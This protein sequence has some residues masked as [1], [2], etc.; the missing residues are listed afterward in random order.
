VL[1]V[2]FDVVV[3]QE[4]VFGIERVPVRSLVEATLDPLSYAVIVTVVRVTSP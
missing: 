3:E 4:Y 1:P 2:S